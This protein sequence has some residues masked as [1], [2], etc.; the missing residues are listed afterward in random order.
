MFFIFLKLLYEYPRQKINH[1][2]YKGRGG[3]TAGAGILSD[4]RTR[5]KNSLPAL[6]IVTPRQNNAVNGNIS[7]EMLCLIKYPKKVFTRHTRLF[8]GYTRI[9]TRA[10]DY[11]QAIEKENIKFIEKI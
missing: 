11:I 2:L 4:K 3:Q 7:G 9:Y 10:R 5:A 1:G 8:T 6:P